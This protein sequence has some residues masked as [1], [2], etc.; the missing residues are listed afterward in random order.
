MTDTDT[1]APAIHDPSAARL[2]I[3][4]RFSYGFGDLAS[5]LYWQT[6]SVYLAIFYTDI[7]GITAA[8]AGTMM[9]ISRFSDAFFDPLMGML[10]DRT[11]TRWGKFRPFL[12]WGCVPLAVVAFSQVA[13]E[14]AD[15]L[16]EAGEQTDGLE[17]IREFVAACRRK[18]DGND[19]V[20]HPQIIGDVVELSL[21]TESG[22]LLDILRMPAS[23][24]P[25]PAEEMSPLIGAFVR[26]VRASPGR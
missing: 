6:I 21:Y 15:F 16:A 9:S 26:L 5:C 8:A 24:L 23:R 7:F 20:C 3:R 2:S 22:E 10:S 25:A 17:E 12:L 19:V 4:E 13:N 1:P 18:A 11:R 14:I